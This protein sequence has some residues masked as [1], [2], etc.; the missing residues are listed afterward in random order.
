MIEFLNFLLKNVYK[1]QF[2]NPEIVDSAFD[3]TVRDVNFHFP[4]LTKTEI[5]SRIISNNNELAIFLFRLG[6]KIHRAELHDLK[7]Q[8]HWLLKQYCSCELYFNN[9]IDDGFYIVHG[10]GSVLGSRN[11]IGK[12]FVMHQGCTIGHKKNG[13]GSGNVIGNNVILYANSSIIGALNIGSN[14]VIG[15]HILISKDVPDNTVVTIKNNRY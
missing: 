4:N 13:A 15:A 5:K 7:A 1:P 2:I 8:I 10:E 11:K 6:Q 3:Q 14:V 9:D 12:G